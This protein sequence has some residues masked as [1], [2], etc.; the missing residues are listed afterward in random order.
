MD[1]RAGEGLRNDAVSQLHDSWI[2]LELGIDAA[3]EPAQGQSL[4]STRPFH[5]FVAERFRQVGE[6]GV[7]QAVPYA[8]DRRPIDA[9]HLRVQFPQ[10]P[11]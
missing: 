1:R 4:G 10:E 5:E 11:P 3:L 2:G 7:G 9:N 8:K 6:L